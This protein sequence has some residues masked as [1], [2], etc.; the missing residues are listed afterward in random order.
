MQYLFSPEGA[1]ATMWGREGIEYELNEVGAPVFSEEW[2]EATQD[3][4]LF[5]SKYNT[6]FYF[7][8]TGLTEAIGRTAHL[9]PEYQDTYAAI[10]EKIV[11]EPW[12]G[13]AEPK[14]PNSDEFIQTEKLTD[15]QNNFDARLV[16]AQSDEDFEKVYEE[17]ISAANA[18]G[19]E[20]LAEYMNAEIARCEALY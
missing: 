14:D 2:T 18:I 17:M 5:A 3:E 12:Y 1:R 15:L 16:T 7:G 6:N 10:R 4:K 19:L 13:L 11:C 8:T 9:G 20:T